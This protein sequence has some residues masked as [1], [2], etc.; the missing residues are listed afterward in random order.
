MVEQSWF[1]S[2]TSPGDA[3]EAPYSDDEYSDI[4]RKIWQRNRTSQGY[5]EDYLNE[6]AVS[7]PAGNEI[8]VASGAALVDGKFYENDAN[9]DNTIATPSVSTRIDRVVLRK[10]WAAQ[11]I[12]I[13][14]LTG[15]EGGGVPALTQDDG[16]TWEISLAQV[17]IT[18][19][20]VI[21]ITDERAI[22]RT[23][24]AEDTGGLTSSFTEIETIDGDGVIVGFDFSNIPATF[25]HLYI[26]GNIRTTDAVAVEDLLLTFNG[27]GGANYHEHVV[28]A[29]NVTVSAAVAANQTNIEIARIVGASALAGYS[30]G[31]SLH[32]PNYA[33]TNLQKIALCQW[34]AIPN[35]TVADWESGQRS[36]QWL[37]T[38]A[39]NQIT[40]KI[41]GAGAIVAG[42]KATLY[43]LG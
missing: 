27:D 30:S 35:T 25:A 18:I 38:S 14:I 32:I 31:F 8:R 24:L 19:V 10:S 28:E 41:N 22:A 34:S 13:A 29:V 6:L 42:S 3:S 39:I 2:S 23:P 21:V 5:I 1:W 36:G 9:E 4:Q 12:R 37:N 40:M 26:I 33:D 17:S 15:V 43:G 16:V 20:S 11:T 7:N